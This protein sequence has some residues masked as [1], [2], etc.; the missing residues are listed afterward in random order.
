MLSQSGFVFYFKFAGN[1]LFSDTFLSAPAPLGFLQASNCL[2][3]PGL[4]LKRS[5]KYSCFEYKSLRIHFHVFQ[6]NKNQTQ[7]DE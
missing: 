4:E 2:D 7:L 3:L 6:P 5:G 1:E